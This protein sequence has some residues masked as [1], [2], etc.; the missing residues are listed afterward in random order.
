MAAAERVQ[1]CALDRGFV[2]EWAK[3]TTWESDCRPSRMSE[4]Q[5]QYEQIPVS[6]KHQHSTQQPAPHVSDGHATTKRDTPHTHAQVR[7]GD[8]A[9][10]TH[11]LTPLITPAGNSTHTHTHTD[12][13][14][15]TLA[16]DGTMRSIT[17]DLSSYCS[18][19]YMH[20]DTAAVAVTMNFS[21]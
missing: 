16:S 3:R 12:T 4:N 9:C 11:L 19:Y 10:N 6:D 15:H 17:A 14:I 13:Y 2:R 21:Q 18:E 5:W 20:H 7:V 1:T 8:V